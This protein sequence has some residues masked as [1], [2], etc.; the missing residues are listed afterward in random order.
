MAFS[1]AK[2]KFSPLSLPPVHTNQPFSAALGREGHS[3][4]ST[5]FPHPRSPLLAF[6]CAVCACSL[7]HPPPA[8]GSSVLQGAGALSLVPA[9]IPWT[10]A[11]TIW[12]RCHPCCHTCP[13]QPK[14]IKDVNLVKDTARALLLHSTEARSHVP[15]L[16]PGLQNSN[17]YDFWAQPRVRADTMLPCLKKAKQTHTVQDRD[18]PLPVQWIS[19]TRLCVLPYRFRNFYFFVI[20]WF[21]HP[22]L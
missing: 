10:P 9:A 4:T 21:L 22:A 11:E 7:A 19:R 17:L 14:D 8:P 20:T 12:P 18:F 3:S 15:S 13:A 6:L 2:Q 16:H 1:G 5:S